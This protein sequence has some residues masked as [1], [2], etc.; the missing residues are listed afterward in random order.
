MPGT[1]NGFDKGILYKSEILA[2]QR[3]ALGLTDAAKIFG[4]EEYYSIA[5]KIYE[6]RVELNNGL[7]LNEEKVRFLLAIQ[8]SISNMREEE[9]KKIEERIAKL[10]VSGLSDEETKQDIDNLEQEKTRYQRIQDTLK[11]HISHIFKD[12]EALQRPSHKEE[13]R[14]E[15][16]PE[17]FDPEQYRDVELRKKVSS[18]DKL[19]KLTK[20]FGRKDVVLVHGYKLKNPD[21]VIADLSL[22]KQARI[23]LENEQFDVAGEPAKVVQIKDVVLPGLKV[24]E[25]ELEQIRDSKIRES[26]QFKRWLEAMELSVVYRNLQETTT[27]AMEMVAVGK[28]PASAE[29][30]SIHSRL[31]TSLEAF[32]DAKLSDN[33]AL[34]NNTLKEEASKLCEE[35]IEK[36]KRILEK[37]EERILDL[38]K[39]EIKNNLKFKALENAKTNALSPKS[40]ISD[41]EAQE[42]AV[43]SALV[44]LNPLSE[45]SAG[46][47]NG[48]QKTAD[49]F[50]FDQINETEIKPIREKLQDRKRKLLETEMDVQKKALQDVVSEIEKLDFKDDKDFAENPKAKMSYLLD[51]KTRL[52][53]VRDELQKRKVAFVDVDSRFNKEEKRLKDFIERAEIRDLSFADLVE[54]IIDRNFDP[55]KTT[56]EQGSITDPYEREIIKKF[57]AIYFPTATFKIEVKNPDG[58]LNQKKTEEAKREH[59]KVKTRIW[60]YRYQDEHYGGQ[61][62]PAANPDHLYGKT[63]KMTTRKL[64]RD[65]ILGGVM[66]EKAY[67]PGPKQMLEYAVNLVADEVEVT[68]V[69]A[70]GKT[71]K[72]Y[73]YDSLKG[74]PDGPA[75]LKAH[76][77]EQFVDT[78]KVTEENFKILWDLYICFDLASVSLA[79][80]QKGT[81]TRSHNT[82][83]SAD[84]QAFRCYPLEVMSHKRNRYGNLDVAQQHLLIFTGKYPKE[85]K[86]SEYVWAGNKDLMNGSRVR[87]TD[88]TQELVKLYIKAYFPLKGIQNTVL[89]GDAGNTEWSKCVFPDQF[90]FLTVPTDKIPNPELYEVAQSGWDQMLEMT[91]GDIGG[92]LT[93]DRIFNTNDGLYT[94]FINSGMGLAKVITGEHHRWFVPMLRYFVGRLSAEFNSDELVD[95]RELRN[96]L[97]EQLKVS[98]SSGLQIDR[99]GPVD[100]GISEF[101]KELEG[102]KSSL[103]ARALGL[104]G[105]IPEILR[106]WKNRMRRNERIAYMQ[107]WYEDKTGEKAH[108]DIS[109]WRLNPLG[110]PDIKLMYD[111]IEER[112]P[113]PKI[114][115]RSAKSKDTS[116]KK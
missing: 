42:D 99:G 30:I 57:Q 102:G 18:Y 77:K 81:K 22:L 63:G 86:N 79:K 68:E 100:Q 73:H 104:M 82:G 47:P 24:L 105:E 64:F 90:S 87:T 26:N 53:A 115:D 45:W 49:R 98:V 39:I 91:I 16:K 111:A 74:N 3:E 66:D 19:R 76:L 83:T 1:E 7:H 93:I 4:N 60:A 107:A 5:K 69:D 21:E 20:V 116:E 14:V 51:L 15:A 13:V 94:K 37:V 23:E 41:V 40:T 38:W 71:I 92:S 31:E 61:Y 9:K 67:G 58:S 48:L 10:R 36:G 97:V 96:R 113:L 108:G 27:Q 52:Y 84:A 6:I 70:S 54:I 85:K 28:T 65:D 46:L 56:A 33:T 55:F 109:L 12:N 112:A 8:S 35:E 59:R 110:D 62:V 72:P 43:N 106:P 29:L 44:A 75:K 17:N 78:G 25:T 101:I 11:R 80:L 50:V 114:I 95:R 103:A 89:P 2:K 32:K 88:E 34:T